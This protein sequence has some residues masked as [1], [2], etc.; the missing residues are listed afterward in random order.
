M[1]EQYFYQDLGKTAGPL[2][3]EEVKGRIRDGR[4]RVFDLLYKDGESAWKIALEHR[5]AL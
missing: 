5:L 1:N 2:S 4:I 3:A